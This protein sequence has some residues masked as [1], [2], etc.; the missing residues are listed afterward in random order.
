MAQLGHCKNL[1][2]V[3][4]LSDKWIQLKLYVWIL[5]DSSYHIVIRW[6]LMFCLSHSC[7][8]I[9]TVTSNFSKYPLKPI[10]LRPVSWQSCVFTATDFVYKY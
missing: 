8:V 1:R 4:I 5:H 10:V 9:I 2:E 7:Y 3:I 6:L